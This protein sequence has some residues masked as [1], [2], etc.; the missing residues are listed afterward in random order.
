[1]FEQRKNGEAL[2]ISL[3]PLV[4]VL[5]RHYSFRVNSIIIFI[6]AIL[7]Q[8]DNYHNEDNNKN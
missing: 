2:A 5:C 7:N 6:M 8:E 3:V 1:M 4:A